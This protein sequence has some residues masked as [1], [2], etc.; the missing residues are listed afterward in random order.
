MMLTSNVHYALVAVT[1]LATKQP[2]SGPL[3]QARATKLTELHRT[4][5]LSVPYLA[6]L[7]K[8]LRDAG[9]VVARR[10]PKGGY[11]LAHR[12]SNITLGSVARAVET[13]GLK[14]VGRTPKPIAGQLNDRFDAFLDSVSVA[15]VALTPL[16]EGQVSAEP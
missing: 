2:R 4:M 13:N 7:F 3:Y 9:L 1:I 15:D 16:A 8:R 11:R 12:A 6:Q 10:G 5:G 14:G